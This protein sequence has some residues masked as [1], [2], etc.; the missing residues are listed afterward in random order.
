[1]SLVAIRST[2]GETPRKMTHLKAIH[3]IVASE[4]RYWKS[5]FPLINNTPSCPLQNTPF[6]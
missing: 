2:Y 3:R 6:S 1:M 5:N 4:G